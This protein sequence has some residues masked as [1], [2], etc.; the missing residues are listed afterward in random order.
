MGVVSVSVDRRTD[1][2]LTFKVLSGW[3]ER[4]VG[5]LGTGPGAMPVVLMRCSSIHTFGMRYPIDVAFVDSEGR[6]LATRRSLFPRQLLASRDAYCVFERPSSL[7]P[8]LEAG[9]RIS[10][11]SF[12]Y[13]GE[14]TDKRKDGCYA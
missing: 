4:L 8:W 3:V 6:V 10:L 2:E 9:D 14:L 1:V 13:G 11:T 12:G 5:L 7:A